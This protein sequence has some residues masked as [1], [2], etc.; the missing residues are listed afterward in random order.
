MKSKIA[1]FLALMTVSSMTLAVTADQS[2]E[3]AKASGGY[4]L[5]D[6][7]LSIFF[8]IFIVVICRRWRSLQRLVLVFLDDLRDVQKK[9]KDASPDAVTIAA[10]LTT[11]LSLLGLYIMIGLILAI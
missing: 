4:R 1:S 5:I 9:I 6:V 8:G 3:Y 11:G 2:L 7:A 10:G